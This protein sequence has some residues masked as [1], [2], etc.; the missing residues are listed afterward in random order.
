MHR[1]L[2]PDEPHVL[3]IQK[4]D[5]EIES[6]SLE[7]LEGIT[8]IRCGFITE[9]DRFISFLTRCPKLTNLWCGTVIPSDPQNPVPASC[10]PLLE[11]FT[12]PLDLAQALVPGRP[13]EE[14][15]A[16]SMSG[17]GQ[18][19]QDVT[20]IARLMARGTKQLRHLQIG[21]LR[22]HDGRIGKLAFLSPRLESLVLFVRDLQ[23]VRLRS[24]Y[25]AFILLTASL[26][27]D[28][29]QTHITQ[30]LNLMPRLCRIG[31]YGVELDGP[32]LEEELNI[33][34]QIL[35]SARAAYPRLTHARFKR[36]IQWSAD[37]EGHW[38]ATYH[39]S[40]KRK[41]TC[42]SP[43]DYL[44]PEVTC[45][46]SSESTIHYASGT[47]TILDVLGS[48]HVKKEGPRLPPEILI[49]VISE[50]QLAH[51][52]WKDVGA[53]PP[54]SIARAI[55]PSKPIPCEPNTPLARPTRSIQSH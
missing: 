54:E 55:R 18:Q 51:Q 40:C 53:A 19:I 33:Q 6:L 43:L 39:D 48:P 2:S 5:A 10:I 13:L 15:S 38:T 45:P 44:A 47:L 52:P 31:A 36:D 22:W 17:G 9:G 16:F 23:K 46:R 1:S 35:E 34:R 14:I 25:L 21:I 24:Y 26:P 28:W 32:P 49:Q 11:R 29:L 20:D 12:G 42:L 4:V 8:E 30:L 7:I 27:K 37:R 3:K 50:I 41:L